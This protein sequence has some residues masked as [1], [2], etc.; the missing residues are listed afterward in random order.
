MLLITEEDIDASKPLGWP[1]VNPE[2]GEAEHTCVGVLSKEL[3]V[4]WALQHKLKTKEE[5]LQQ[6]LLEASNADE[7]VQSVAKEI[8]DTQKDLVR[9]EVLIPLFLDW[10]FPVDAHARREFYI[11]PGFSV[12]LFESKVSALEA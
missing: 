12:N 1:Q 2:E 9:L 10:D 8:W 5:A 7:S 11:G 4:L 3:K 6:K